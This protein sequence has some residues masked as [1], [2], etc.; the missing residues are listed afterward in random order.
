MWIFARSRNIDLVSSLSLLCPIIYN[1]L[2]DAVLGFSIASFILLPCGRGWGFI[3]FLF[4]FKPAWS[5]KKRR[6]RPR[7]FKTRGSGNFRRM[8]HDRTYFRRLKSQISWEL[9]LEGKK[10]DR[11]ELIY[12]CAYKVTI[13]EYGLRGLSYT[14]GSWNTKFRRDHR[15]LKIL[16]QKGKKFCSRFSWLIGWNV[17][18]FHILQ[19]TYCCA[20]VAGNLF[21]TIHIKAFNL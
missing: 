14:Y 10:T 11:R 16:M 19:D 17:W 7:F 1:L 8:H 12:V 6:L 3:S 21:L 20:K 9:N 5:F 15:Q 18:N 4:W 2:K 13:L